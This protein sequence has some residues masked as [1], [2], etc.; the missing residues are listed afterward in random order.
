MARL[1]GAH[2]CSHPGQPAP[3]QQAVGALG[4]QG[5]QA[6]EQR[7]LGGGKVEQVGGARVRGPHED[8]QAGIRLRR[9]SEQGLQGVAA[10]ERAD[11]RRV[12]AQA[13]DLAPRRRRRSEQR[14]RVGGGAHRNVVSLAV[15]DHQQAG[16]AS[17]G[18]GALERRPAGC[19]EPLE[20][21]QLELDGDAGRTRTRD[22][23]FAA[24]RRP[25]RPLARRRSR[26]PPGNPRPAQMDPDPVPGRAG[27]RRSSTRAARRSAK[28]R[29]SP[30]PWTSAPRRPR[31]WA[32]ARRRS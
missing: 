10:Q 25:L 14:L 32:R 4:D 18:R 21:G 3:A 12:R 7:R 9:P 16:L 23:R 11:G 1:G 20:A 15:G 2:H 30:L 24:G 26:P 6:L 31:T 8:E 13:A 27:F 19:A 28:A 5:G 29:L 17:G 22:Q